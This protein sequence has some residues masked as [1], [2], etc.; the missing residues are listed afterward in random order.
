MD[1]MKFAKTKMA[2]SEKRFEAFWGGIKEQ[3]NLISEKEFKIIDIH[4]HSD[5]CFDLIVANTDND[6]ELTNV[7]NWRITVEGGLFRKPKI[8]LL[9]SEGPRLDEFLK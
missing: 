7:E 5:Q 9:I 1:K 4:D 3:L 8:K 6:T 2:E